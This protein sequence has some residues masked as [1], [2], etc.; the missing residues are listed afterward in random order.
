[1]LV[2][3]VGLFCLFFFGLE[4]LGFVIIKGFYGHESQLICHQKR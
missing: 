1:M 4:L 2:F 3:E